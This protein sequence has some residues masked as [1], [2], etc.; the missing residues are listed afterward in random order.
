MTMTVVKNLTAGLALAVAIVGGS[1]STLAQKK[2]AGNQITT[3]DPRGAGMAA[4]QGT[5]AQQGLDSGTIVGYYID[6]DAVAHGFVRTVDG[7]YTIIDVPGAAGTQAYGINNKGTV[8]GWWFEP[9][10]ANGSVYHG[11]LRDK[12]GNLTYFDV[13]GAGPYQSQGTSPIVSI[14]LPLSINLGGTVSGT[15]VDTNN[16]PHCFVRSVDGNITNPIDPVGSV[17]TVGDTNGINRQGATTGGYFTADGVTHAFLRDPEGV[18][19]SFDGPGAGKMAGQGSYF[20]M[21]NDAGTIPGVSIDSNFVQHGFIL[22]RDGTLVTVNVAG[23]GTGQYQGTLTSAVSVAGIAGGN[24]FDASGAS[25]GFVR[26]RHGT[27]TTFDVRGEGTGSGQG[28]TAVNS[29]NAGGAAV[30]WYIDANGAYHGYIY[31]YGSEDD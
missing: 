19:T 22:S 29:I 15:Y 9:P 17:G 23:A 28:V 30:G 16:V 5:F 14:P 18:I 7:R 4:G 21:I 31:Q 27:I 11:Y 3:F 2:V 20:N 8:V 26:S 24:Y 10:T 6:A 12:D 1:G 13:P 25:H